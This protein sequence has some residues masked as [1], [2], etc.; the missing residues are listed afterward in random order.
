MEEEVH[1]KHLANRVFLFV[2]DEIMISCIFGA[3]MASLPG[4]DR[5]FGS[6]Q[7]NSACKISSYMNKSGEL[8]KLHAK[9]KEGSKKIK[10]LHEWNLLQQLVDVILL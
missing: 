2:R 7:I 4:Y 10:E 3:V 9:W 6:G 1:V 8:R 5:C